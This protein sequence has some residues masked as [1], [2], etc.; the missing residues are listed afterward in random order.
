MHK[1]RYAWDVG[2]GTSHR[3]PFYVQ[4]HSVSSEQFGWPKE[5]KFFEENAEGG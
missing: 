5:K 1:E 4:V 2:R 3:G